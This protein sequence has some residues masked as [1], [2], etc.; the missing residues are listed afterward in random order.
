MIESMVEEIF[1]DLRYR[2]EEWIGLE[3]SDAQLAIFSPAQRGQ[4]K[5]VF[6]LDAGK[7]MRRCDFLIPISERRLLASFADPGKKA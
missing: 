2:C 7:A 6:C 3:G 1:N 4:P 5:M